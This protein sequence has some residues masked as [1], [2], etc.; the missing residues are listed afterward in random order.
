MLT[1]LVKTAARLCA[2]DAGHIALPKGE[3]YRTA[4]AVAMSPE[5]EAMVR[6]QSYRPGRGT[7]VGRALAER[8]VVQIADIG[9]DPEHAVRQAAGAGYIRTILAVPLLRQGEPIGAFGL[10]RSRVEPFTE[11]QV[12]LVTTFA[13]QAVIAIE[14]SRLFEA[15]QQRTRELSE[16]LEQQTATADVLRV[17]VRRRVIWSRYLPPFWTTRRGFAR[18]SSPAC[19]CARAMLCVWLHIMAR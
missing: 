11:R 4:A 14:N 13:A 7:A 10:A 6:A 12:A 17:S 18:P 8:R 5:M 15:E 1:T 9:V 19:F 2:A 16:S 3:D